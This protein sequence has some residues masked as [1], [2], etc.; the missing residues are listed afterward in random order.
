MPAT[1]GL[2]P[3]ALTKRII[4]SKLFLVISS[5]NPLSASFAPNSI[6]TMF[7]VVRSSKAFKRVSPPLVVSPLIL[8]L[9]IS[10]LGCVFDSE[11]F[12]KATQPDSRFKPYSADRLSPITNTLVG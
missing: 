10:V 1:I 7:G 2:A 11:F 3:A 5:G 6:S 9:I 4:A 8:A 12:S